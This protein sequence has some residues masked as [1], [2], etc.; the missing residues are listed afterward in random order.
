MGR[1]PPN[2]FYIDLDKRKVAH[3]SSG[4]SFWFF[5]YVD[6]RGWLK[7]TEAICQNNKEWIGDRR[8]LLAAAKLAALAFGMKAKRTLRW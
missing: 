1:F 7:S 3:R 8:E 5:E 2:D 4:I 6:E